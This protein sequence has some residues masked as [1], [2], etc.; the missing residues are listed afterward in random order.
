M[1]WAVLGGVLLILLLGLVPIIW[2]VRLAKQTPVAEQLNEV[3][4]DTQKLQ[5]KAEK[6][7]THVL[8]ARDHHRLRP[9]AQRP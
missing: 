2:N 4:R 7:R 5:R 6:V 8:C 1:N 3:L 9:G